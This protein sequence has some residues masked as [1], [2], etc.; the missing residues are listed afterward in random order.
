MKFS[1][2][3]WPGSP[4]SAEVRVGIF[5]PPRPPSLGRESEPGRVQMGAPG[6][7][8]EG[9]RLGQ[10]AVLQLQANKQGVQGKHGRQTAWEAD[11][12]TLN[13]FSLRSSDSDFATAGTGLALPRDSLTS[14][15]GFRFASLKRHLQGLEPKIPASTDWGPTVLQRPQRP[16]LGERSKEERSSTSAWEIASCEKGGR[17]VSALPGIV[18]SFLPTLL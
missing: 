16:H 6:R 18:H 15:K 4:Q 7:R 3:P 2:R 14:F 17:R 12:Q 5:F 8:S 1:S 11:R 10:T 13:R 9:G